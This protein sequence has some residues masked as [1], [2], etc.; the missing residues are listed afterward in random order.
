MTA[1]T[2]ASN[3]T[4]R[5]QSLR[6]AGRAALALFVWI[7]AAAT[8]ASATPA[9]AQMSPGAVLASKIFAIVVFAYAYMRA[10]P[11]CTIDHA[12]F[13]GVSWLVLSIITE[14]V[15]SARSGHQ[16]FALLGS[17][18]HPFARDILLFI[19]VAAPALFARRRSL[20]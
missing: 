17:P 12:L 10:T 7:G 3:A 20:E 15:I 4:H 5:S 13:V 18:Q 6:W 8:V 19:W 14:V 11:D 16:W 2:H 1:L 9:F